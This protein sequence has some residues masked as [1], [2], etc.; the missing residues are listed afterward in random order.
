M[1]L[2]ALMSSS[3]ITT[4]LFWLSD[5]TDTLRKE[6]YKDERSAIMAKAEARMAA[7]GNRGWNEMI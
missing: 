4:S 5:E 3:I 1:M 6:N 2:V 7:A